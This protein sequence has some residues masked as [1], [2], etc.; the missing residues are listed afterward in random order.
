VR[1]LIWVLVV[2]GPLATL[3]LFAAGISLLWALAFVVVSMSIMAAILAVLQL[4]SGAY[5]ETFHSSHNYTGVPPSGSD[6]G[7]GSGG[8]WDGGSGGGDGGG[9]G[10]G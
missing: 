1:N 2:F 4:W 10:S 3:V 8:G 5:D 6:I 7:L 9:G